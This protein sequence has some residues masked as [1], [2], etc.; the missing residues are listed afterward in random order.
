MPFIFCFLLLSTP[1]PSG[2]I[3]LVSFSLFF[4]TTSF[5]FLKKYSSFLC[6]LYTYTSW[7]ISPY[8]LII[9]LLFKQQRSAFCIHYLLNSILSSP[10]LS[11]FPLCICQCSISNP[12]SQSLCIFSLLVID[13]E[14]FSLH[15]HCNND[16]TIYPAT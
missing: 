1:T 5:S 4:S 3:M 11:F 13:S 15:P 12:L 6:I 10:Y 16:F 8:F 2:I 14:I 7:K 9:H